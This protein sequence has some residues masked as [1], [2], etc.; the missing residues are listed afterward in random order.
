MEKV[1]Q[2]RESYDNK[3]HPYDGEPTVAITPVMIEGVHCY[4]FT[5]ATPSSDR[6]IIFL[7]GGGFAM[8][9][10]ETHGR[11]VTHFAKTLQAK[12]LFIEYA[13]APENPY[14]AG[15]NDVVTVYRE[16]TN[17]HPEAQLNLI[18]DSAGGS[19]IVSAIGEMLK[20]NLPLPGAVVLI[21]PWISLECEYPS[22]NENA[23]L[24]ISLNR[25]ALHMF[26]RA[27]T[28]NTPLAVSSPEKALLTRFPPVLIMVGTNEILLDDSR[29]FY[30]H[31]K[32]IQERSKLSIYEDQ[33]HVWLK[34]DIHKEASRRALAEMADFINGH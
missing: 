5:P 6:I 2:A 20:M 3:P 21:S 32:S 10:V 23:H 13:L 30:N 34:K 25:E 33:P 29:H 12:I 28:G 14:P 22:M 7:H 26:A 24:D 1:L 18:G 9:S 11:M 27:Y 8:G 4:W 16:I 15:L 17:R 31:I 19:L